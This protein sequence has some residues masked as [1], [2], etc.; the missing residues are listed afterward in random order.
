[1]RN[2][3]WL[4]RSHQGMLTPPTLQQ[5]CLS[6]GAHFYFAVN[7][8]RLSLR[9]RVLPEA[10]PTNRKMATQWQGWRLLRLADE[11]G[12]RKPRAWPTQKLALIV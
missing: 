9:G 10:T 1:M 4:R 6:A 11:A 7:A 5:P 8:C 12:P 2:A 3:T